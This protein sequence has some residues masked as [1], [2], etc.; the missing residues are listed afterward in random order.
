MSDTFCALPFQELCIGSEGTARVCCVMPDLVTE[1]GAPMSLNVHTI[2]EIWN[3]AYMRNIRRG[4]LKGERISACEVCYLNEAAGGH[5]YRTNVGLEP[6]KGQR[7]TRS[8]MDRY[9]AR[10]GFRVGEHPNFFKLEIGN[11]CNLKC[12]MCYGGNSSQI[13]RDP[14]HSKWNGGMDPLHAIWRGGSARIGPEARIGVRTSGLFPQESLDENVCRWTDGHGIFNVPLQSGT[15][16]THLEIS[17]HRTGIH[18]QHF[19]VII[20]GR[21]MAKGVLQN[22]DSPVKI[23][24]HGF[25][26]ATELV[27]EILSNKILE[28]A[29]QAERGLPLSDLVLRRAFPASNGAIHPQ[30]LSPRFPANGPWYMDDRKMFD[31]I[32][33]SPET[34]RRLCITGG[35]PLIN[36]R[37]AEVLDFLIARGAA[38]H[39]YLELVTNCTHIDAETIER[40]KKFDQLQLYISLD[41]IQE[42][43][44]YIR[45]PARWSVVEENLRKLKDEYGMPCYVETVVQVY[46]VLHLVELQR[47]CDATDLIVTMNVLRDPN[48]MAVYN[49][50]PRITKAAAAKLFAYHETDCRDVQKPAVLALARYLDQSSN[51]TDPGIIRELMTFTN[52]LDLTRGQN[53]RTTDPELVQLLAEDGYIWSDE[54]WLAKD[55][56]KMRPARERDYAWL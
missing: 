31:E 39:I 38:P 42:T 33:K 8:E 17:F 30:V 24:L 3:S 45:Y 11:L 47:F 41:G 19:E 29:G 50:P 22:G 48:R 18:G 26:D 4:M 15:R 2:D 54:T 52:D 5:S 51:P 21:P 16:L 1:H 28:T 44:E 55:E 10:S 46:N 53:I 9:G 35:E 7:R 27:I 34:L 36:D 14:V 23:D 37:V 40:L 25:G 56:V 20:N 32:L 13:E 49:L 12:R 43:Y 6:I